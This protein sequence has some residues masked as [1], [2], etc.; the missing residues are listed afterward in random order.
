MLGISPGSKIQYETPLYVVPTSNASTSFRVRPWY[1]FRG[2]ILTVV[3]SQWPQLDRKAQ[4]TYIDQPPSQRVI[5]HDRKIDV[6]MVCTPKVY[7]H[8]TL[9]PRSVHL[10]AAQIWH[11]SLS[12]SCMEMKISRG[13]NRSSSEIDADSQPGRWMLN[14]VNTPSGLRLNSLSA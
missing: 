8:S 11:W 13:V 2:I 5:K 10:K 14:T 4:C 12:R 1:G 7:C 3:S 6:P 9:V